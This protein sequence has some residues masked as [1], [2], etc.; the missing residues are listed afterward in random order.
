MITLTEIA[1]TIS[2]QS[3]TCYRHHLYKLEG[4]P[5]PEVHVKSRIRLYSVKQAIKI[6]QIWADKYNKDF[7]LAQFEKEIKLLDN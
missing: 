7:D 6:A 4:L 3:Y 5:E 2:N 1:V